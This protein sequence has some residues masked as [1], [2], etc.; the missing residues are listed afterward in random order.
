MDKQEQKHHLIDMMKSDE[1]L[2]IYNEPTKHCYDCNRLL[3][4]CT[5]IE[6]TIDMKQE[7][8]EE[9]S[10]RFEQL[11]QE[12]CDKMKLHFEGGSYVLGFQDGAKWQQEQDKNMY[13][14]QDIRKILNDIILVNPPH[15]SM[16][17]SGYGEYPDTYEITEKGID[18]IIERFKKK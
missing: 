4:D 7:T 11:Q 14:E 13:S 12:D 16:L 6:D 5:C 9:A 3:E 2:G 1:E 8:L 10:E 17:K 18:Y 15:I